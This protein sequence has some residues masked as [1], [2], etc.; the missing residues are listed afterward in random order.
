M[1][2]VNVEPGVYCD[3]GELGWGLSLHSDGANGIA[4]YLFCHDQNR[5]RVW[6]VINQ[7]GILTK[8]NGIG[9][10]GEYIDAQPENCGIVKLTGHKGGIVDCELI[11]T[12]N[13]MDLSEQF[14]PPRPWPYT[15]T[16]TLV[17]LL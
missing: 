12:Q 8:T 11:L 1:S 17:K 13:V 3:T 10:P 14:S 15:H 16:A 5:D 2:I 6:L 4:G 7:N 9:F